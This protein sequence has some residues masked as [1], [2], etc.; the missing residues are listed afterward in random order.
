M[1]PDL[2]VLPEPNIDVTAKVG[3]LLLRFMLAQMKKY[4]QRFQLV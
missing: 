1:R 4:S 3:K 2:V